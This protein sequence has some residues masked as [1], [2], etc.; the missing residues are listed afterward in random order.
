MVN[1]ASRDSNFLLFTF[2]SC[3]NAICHST[4]MRGRI[5]AEFWMFPR[6]T[7]SPPFRPP[8]EFACPAPRHTTKARMPC[9]GLYSRALTLGRR[10]VRTQA[11]QRRHPP[12]VEAKPTIVGLVLLRTDPPWLATATAS[13]C[14]HQRFPRPSLRNGGSDTSGVRG[15]VAEEHRWVEL[16]PTIHSLSAH[17]QCLADAGG[18]ES[19]QVGSLEHAARHI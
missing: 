8:C 11:D 18:R 1:Y 15:T 3:A 7:S 17:A 4:R 19:E 5:P 9:A 14:A 2:L 12:H 6:Q 16:V 13:A 10:A